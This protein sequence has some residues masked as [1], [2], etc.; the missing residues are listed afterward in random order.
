MSRRRLPERKIRELGE[1]L[2]YCFILHTPIRELEVFNVP[3]DE[4]LGVQITTEHRI[5]LNGTD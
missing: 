4:T 1:H 5:C 2:V 3:R